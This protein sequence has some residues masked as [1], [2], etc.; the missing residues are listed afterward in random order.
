M[1]KILIIDDEPYILELL[2]INLEVAGYLV[3]TLISGKNLVDICLEFQ[4]EIILLDIMLPDIDGLEL[5]KIIKS[6]SNLNKIG[7]ILVSAKGEIDDKVY[8]LNLGADD[9]IAKPFSIKEILSRVNALL[10][11][12]N[13]T[14]KVEKVEKNVY[15]HRELKFDFNNKVVYKN[16]APLD[17]THKELKLL[18]LLILNVNKVVSREVILNKIW[19]KEESTKIG[20]SLDVYIRKLR[21]K[22]DNGNFDSY[23]ETVH[24]RGYKLV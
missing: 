9:Y 22:L 15:Q 2:K 7:I 16:E 3:K 13:L 19:S 20:R 12:V 8:G 18:E 23:I 10:R 11:R 17:L 4:P 14:C 1:N 6:H 5:C 21:L 24:G